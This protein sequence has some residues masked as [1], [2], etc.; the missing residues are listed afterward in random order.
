MG[1]MAQ[2]AI[3]FGLDPVVAPDGK[4][5]CDSSYSQSDI[6]R[7]IWG[8][9][10]N[11]CT[12]SDNRYVEDFYDIEVDNSSKIEGHAE[13]V[14]ERMGYRVK[15]G[16]TYAYKFY[17]NEIFTSDQV[18]KKVY[19]SHEGKKRFRRSRESETHTY[20]EWQELGYQVRRGEKAYRFGGRYYF[21]REQVAWI[22]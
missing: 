20:D 5:W 8:D 21:S 12:G 9:L 10:Q 13:R 11:E 2:D 7:E 14:W 4:S 16:E 3:S 15:Y 17:G 18:V 6:S 22:G 1:S 19:S